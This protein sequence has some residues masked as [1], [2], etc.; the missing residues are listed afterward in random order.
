MLHG[1][2]LGLVYQNFL[3]NFLF[4][5]VGLVLVESVNTDKN[6]REW[7]ENVSTFV[8][9]NFLTFL[10]FLGI[11]F[12][13][14]C[15]LPP[16]KFSDLFLSSGYQKETYCVVFISLVLI[17]ILPWYV[18]VTAPMLKLKKLSNKRG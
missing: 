8:L 13:R 5:W 2:K 15:K 1:M 3:K 18:L 10:Y 12:G 4:I 11:T 6:V 9:V 14:F 7:S 17:D 16:Q